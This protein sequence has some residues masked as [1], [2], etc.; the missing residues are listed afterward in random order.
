MSVEVSDGP[1]DCPHC[2]ADMVEDVRERTISI[3]LS[4]PE[5]DGDE[6]QM[7]AG[8][9]DLIGWV[10]EECGCIETT[11]QRGDPNGDQEDDEEDQS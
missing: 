1:M 9:A 7:D 4:G 8:E 5:G 11:E 3:N 6:M 10:C 2:G